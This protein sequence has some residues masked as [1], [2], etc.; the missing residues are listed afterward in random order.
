MT[1]ALS[2]DAAAGQARREG[3]LADPSVELRTDPRLHPGLRAVFA[4]YGLD[5]HAAPPPLDRSA[6]PQA[7]AE[8]VG[9]CHAAF[10]GLYAAMPAEWP[11]EV[12]AEVTHRVETTRGADGNDVTL[13]IFRPAG[14][15]GRC[16][17]WFTCTAAG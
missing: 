17:A 5:G 12:P 4:T 9:A 13:H 10:E 14:A 11:G 16:P 7:V 6:G 1:Q 8:F 2:H 15:R 3:R